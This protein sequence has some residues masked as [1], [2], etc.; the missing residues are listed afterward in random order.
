[1][2]RLVG[3]GVL[4]ILV[5]VGLGACSP[6]NLDVER[7]VAAEAYRIERGDRSAKASEA[8]CEV[9]SS[10]RHGTTELVYTVCTVRGSRYELQANYFGPAGRPTSVDI[11]AYYG[12]LPSPMVVKCGFTYN[13]QRWNLGTC[14]PGSAEP[15]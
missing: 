10:T 2:R 6:S 7:R 13:G 15:R 1:M 5:V 11:R 14:K 8:E 4:A 12:V 3:V 9:P